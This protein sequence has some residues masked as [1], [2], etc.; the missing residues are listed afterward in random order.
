[1]T[2]ADIVNKELFVVKCQ[3]IYR[4]RRII[5][6]VRMRLRISQLPFEIW[7][8]ISYTS[9]E[10]RK[11]IRLFC[12]DLSS[13]DL[14]LNS[15]MICF[16]CKREPFV[17]VQL[18]FDWNGSFGFCS[19]NN[20]VFCVRCAR[21]WV[22]A[23]VENKSLQCVNSCCRKRVQ[24]DYG[25]EYED[26]RTLYFVN[27]NPFYLYMGYGSWPRHQSHHPHPKLYTSMDKAGVGNV[28][29]YRCKQNCGSINNSIYHLRNECRQSYTEQRELVEKCLKLLR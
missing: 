14:R 19:K 29:C 9:L 15:N 22:T 26:I 20:S 28:I 5:N 23:C 16:L 25:T 27:N 8:I 24:H 12:K 17:P 11:K 2:Y 4:Q 13:I 21:A 6:D 3:R 10:V 7:Q 1:M 18:R